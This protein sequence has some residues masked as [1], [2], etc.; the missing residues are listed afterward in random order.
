MKHSALYLS[1]ILFFVSCAKPP[2]ETCKGGRS[3]KHYDFLESI[4]RVN[5]FDYVQAIKEIREYG[6]GNQASGKGYQWLRKPENMRLFY[7]SVKAVGLFNF[8]SQVEFDQPLFT[9][10]YPEI[11]WANKSLSQLIDQFLLAYSDSTGIDPYYQ[12]FWKRR[13]AENNE[14]VVYEIFQDIQSTYAQTSKGSSTP[15]EADSTISSLLAYEVQWAQADSAS[16]DRIQIDY[17]HYLK[18]IGLY[19]SAANLLYILRDN[20]GQAGTFQK[21]IEPI[22][23]DSIACSAY[24]D[25]RE[26]ADWFDDVFDYGL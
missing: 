5:Y 22:E 19:A 2:E 4:H 21:L 7:G 18:E 12:K 15:W 24:W 6:T 10:Y 26:G 8:I 9:H 16:L 1:I 11:C 20:Y 25:W 13:I 14:E 23:T 3:D 17:F